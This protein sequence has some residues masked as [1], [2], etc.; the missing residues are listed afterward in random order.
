MSFSIIKDS[1][2]STNRLVELPETIKN[3]YDIINDIDFDIQ[4]DS[5]SLDYKNW[6]ETIKL[7]YCTFYTNWNNSVID[8]F[9]TAN[10]NGIDFDNQNLSLQA[11][12]KINVR[13]LYRSW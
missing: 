7:G 4:N 13:Q 10:F 2:T 3:I 5:F 9:Y 8:E 12:S 11:I 6:E 1:V